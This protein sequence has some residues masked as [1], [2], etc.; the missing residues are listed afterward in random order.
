VAQVA[1]LHLFWNKC[2]LITKNVQLLHKISHKSLIMNFPNSSIKTV[3][4]YLNDGSDVVYW[5][6][7]DFIYPPCKLSKR[8]MLLFTLFRWCLTQITPS[9]RSVRRPST[10]AYYHVVR[11]AFWRSAT[12]PAA[13]AAGSTWTCDGYL[14]RACGTATATSSAAGHS[15]TSTGTSLPCSVVYGTHCLFMLR[16]LVLWRSFWMRRFHL[17]V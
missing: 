3:S 7:Y 8:L 13:A 14:L 4:F 17:S 15:T 10:L 6:M 11:T 9:T 16:P 5:K 2:D 1:L 12:S